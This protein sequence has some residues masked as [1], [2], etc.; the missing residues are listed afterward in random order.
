VKLR[1]QTYIWRC[2][3]RHLWDRLTLP[4]P[5]HW[6]VDVTM[7]H[8]QAGNPGALPTPS[9]QG[10]RDLLAAFPDLHRRRWSESHP[11]YAPDD[12][13]FD[14][15][16]EGWEMLSYAPLAGLLVRLGVR[17]VLELGCGCGHLFTHLRR[18]G[19]TAYLGIDGNPYAVRMNP[20]LAGYEQHFRTLDIGRHIDLR[21]QFDAVVLLEVLE[22][23]EA[24][25]V[26]ILLGNVRRHLHAGS[27]VI[28]TASQNGTI[29]IHVTVQPRD[30]WLRQ[31][32]NAGLVP[33]SDAARIEAA[34]YRRHPFNWWRGSSTVFALRRA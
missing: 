31:F 18:L 12:A 20:Y 4:P 19:L 14:P 9:Y 29:D 6:P 2:Q 22:H 25:R 5:A 30:W 27:L 26:P 24:D 23:I 13:I 21:A 34:I 11:G 33:H 17:S 15:A 16:T 28:G 1:R 10:G 32:E 7:L 8:D 3:L